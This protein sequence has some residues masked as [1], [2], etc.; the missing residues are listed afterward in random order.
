MRAL[1]LSEIARFN[2]RSESL[3][4]LAID[5][6]IYD[7]THFVERHPGGD[8]VIRS[9]LGRD[10]SVEFSLIHAARPPRA[11]LGRTRYAR[12]LRP[13]FTDPRDLAQWERL[14]GALDDVVKL[15]N[16]FSLESEVFLRECFRGEP[17]TTDPELSRPDAWNPYKANLLADVAARV[18]TLYLPRLEQA[19]NEA[20]P[21][22]M[23]AA[24]IQGS[25]TFASSMRA[26]AS[27]AVVATRE[28][29]ERY[30]DEVQRVL[31]G[32]VIRAQQAVSQ[33]ERLASPPP[34]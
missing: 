14:S 16:V 30:V 33:L 21:E 31:A 2:D 7:V 1:F 28:G 13:A 32:G 4:L 34:A 29:C 17:G 15:E 3:K 11:S 27:A 12:L 25:D 22:A 6:T 18:R 9:L 5:D 10:G 8:G 24:E 26:L 20:V 23:L 19:L